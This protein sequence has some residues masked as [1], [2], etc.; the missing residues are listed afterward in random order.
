MIMNKSDNHYILGNTFR[1][2]LIIIALHSLI[3]GLGLILFPR[4]LIPLFGFGV[5]AENFFFLQSGMFYCIMAIAYAMLGLW[6]ERK[7]GL[8]LL[9]FFAKFLTTIFLLSFYFLSGGA[10]T[11]LLSALLDFIMGL[12]ILWF[13]L[14]LSW[15]LNNLEFDLSEI[16]IINDLYGE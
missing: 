6:P 9:T 5:P 1:L 11:L 4:A 15:D 2:V 13:Y 8:M 3:L 12:A 7:E 16:D 14:D 10:W